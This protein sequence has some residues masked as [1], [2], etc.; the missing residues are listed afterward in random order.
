MTATISVPPAL[1]SEA[2]SHLGRSAEQVGFFYAR[3]LP[4]ARQFQVLEWRPVG[5][6]ALKQRDDFHVELAE[7]AKVEALQYATTSG[8]VLGEVHS[9]VPTPVRASRGRM[10]TN[11]ASGSFTS[12]GVCGVGPISPSLS[13]ARRLTGSSGSTTSP[14]ASN[15]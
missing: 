8:L 10:S 1:V 11:C 12:A 9:T 3:Y 2:S 6:A 4:D 5:Q 7:Q 15:S 14:S 13:P